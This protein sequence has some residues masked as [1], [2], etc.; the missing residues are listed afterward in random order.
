MQIN[1]STENTPIK[2]D[3]K[4]DKIAQNSKLHNNTFTGM[5]RMQRLFK[6]VIGNGKCVESAMEGSWE[7][8]SSRRM[9]TERHGSG[10]DHGD[11]EG[12]TISVSEKEF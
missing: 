8:P 3:M 7:D 6:E 9:E 2:N 12:N 4:Q 10:K 11:I 1:F 5:P